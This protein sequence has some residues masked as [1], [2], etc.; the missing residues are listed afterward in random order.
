[1]PYKF[2][3]VMDELERIDQYKDTTFVFMVEA[4][5]RGHEVYFLALSDLFARADRAMGFARR[6]AVMREAA[7]YR[8][9]DSGG[10]YPLDSFDAIFM[11]KDP[12]ADAAYLYATMLLSLVDSRRSFVLNHPAGLREA[13][14]KLYTLNFPEVIPPTVVSS[15]IARLKQFINEQGGEAIVKPLDG[16]GGEGVFLASQNDRNLNA[17][18]E[19]VTQFGQRLTMGQRYIPEIRNG[20]KRIIVLDGEPVGATLRVP[21]PSENRGNIHVGGLCVKAELTDR[22]RQ[23]CQV[24][25]PRLVRDGLYF[26]GLDVIGEYLT[27]VNVTSP[28]GVQEIDRLDNV[29]LESRVIDF[30][31]ARVGALRR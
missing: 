25:K 17:I 12:P 11:R 26:V 28:T 3:F 29:S 20:D 16:H 15:S 24:L 30:V 7:H 1:M 18:L 10:D 13:N 9:L 31:E 4:L 21:L 8:W 2:A 19:T 14:E 22:D 23:I 27:E 6:C 5:A